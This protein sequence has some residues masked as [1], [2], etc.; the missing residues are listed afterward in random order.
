MGIDLNQ[1]KPMLIGYYLLTGILGLSLRKRLSIH[2]LIK[3]VLIALF[4]RIIIKDYLIGVA[5]GP[6]LT[7]WYYI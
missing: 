6:V 7:E 4:I 1:S 3:M 2:S 5:L